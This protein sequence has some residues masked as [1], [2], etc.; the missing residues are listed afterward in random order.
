LTISASRTPYGVKAKTTRPPVR[1]GTPADD[2]LSRIQVNISITR[3]LDSCD[4]RASFE[5]NI[6]SW[7]WTVGPAKLRLMLE[8]ILWADLS[9]YQTLLK[10]EESRTP[11]P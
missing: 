7:D 10:F 3:K 4:F 1:S 6:L 9:D 8:V 11:L 5:T 2:K